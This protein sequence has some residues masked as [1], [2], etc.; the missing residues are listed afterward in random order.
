[1]IVRG[2]CFRL[3]YYST[4]KIRGSSS[5]GRARRSQCRGQGFDPPLLHIDMKIIKLIPV[6]LFCASISAAG[7]LDGYYQ[8]I[9]LTVTRNG[10]PRGF[11]NTGLYISVGEKR[12]KIAGAWRGYP[13]KRDLIVERTVGDSLVLRD[14]ENQ[15][16]YYKFHVRDN[17]I[18]GRHALNYDDGT[19]EVIE[20]RAVV[21]K[22]NQDEINRIKSRKLFIQSHD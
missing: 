16:S 17:K 19:R 1:M 20:T 10:N 12:I 8:V 11:N 7:L 15:S 9:S 21:K 3:F 14:T 6:I 18:S 5:V 13:I 2:I 22:L 4:T